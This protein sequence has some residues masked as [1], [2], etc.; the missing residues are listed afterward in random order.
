MVMKGILPQL[1]LNITAEDKDF[2]L[3]NGS[4]PVFLK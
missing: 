2:Q 4:K 1:I 3:Q